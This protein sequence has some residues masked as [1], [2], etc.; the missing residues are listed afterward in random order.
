MNLGASEFRVDQMEASM[1]IA[2]P[3]DEERTPFDLA[4]FYSAADGETLH[5]TSPLAALQDFL[6]E[7]DNGD[8]LALRL[9]DLKDGLTVVGYVRESIT[10][11]W[12]KKKATWMAA[13]FDE[14]IGDEYGNAGIGATT[15]PSAVRATMEASILA[16]ITEAANGYKVWQCKAIADK[17]YPQDML[18]ALGLQGSLR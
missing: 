7:T 5:Y 16:A 12:L 1:P 13:E 14:A 11:Q 10:T 8:P 9:E 6:D 15:L 17:H 18:I 4:H 3:N 2:K